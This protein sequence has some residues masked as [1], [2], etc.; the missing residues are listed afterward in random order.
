MTL[1]VLEL[2]VPKLEGNPADSEILA[3]LVEIQR[4][5]F[6]F[7][8]TFVLS[9]AFWYLHQ[10]VLQRISAVTGLL[11]LCEVAFLLFVCLLP[12]SAALFGRF[13]YSPAAMLIYSGHQLILGSLLALQW[14]YA[15]R[16]KLLVPRISSQDRRKLATPLRTLPAVCLCAV[17]IAAIR[18]LPR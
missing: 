1:I 12:F 4:P 14:E 18:L 13:F 11:Y 2:Q 9:A 15:C 16:R 6:A 5:L 8:L 10:T 17:I 7:L 3:K